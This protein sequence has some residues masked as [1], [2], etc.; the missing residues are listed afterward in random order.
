MKKLSIE[1]I[2]NEVSQRPIYIGWNIFLFA[3]LVAL[4]F[5][6]SDLQSKQEQLAREVEYNTNSIK[7]VA[8]FSNETRRNLVKLESDVEDLDDRVFGLWGL[9]SDVVQLA[10]DVSNMEWDV[11]GLQV[12][13]ANLEWDLYSLQRS[14]NS[15]T[16]DVYGLELTLR[17]LQYGR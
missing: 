10:S 12:D 2:R 15:L 16:S 4:F 1:Y 8:D 17:Q 6:L 9:E 3:L 11:Y 13:V 7:V 5:F 14:V